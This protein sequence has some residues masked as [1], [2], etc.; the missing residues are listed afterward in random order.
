MANWG[1][2][3]LGFQS[4]MR[5]LD[6]LTIEIGTDAVYVVGSNVEYSVHQ[7]LGTR[8]MEPNPFLRPAAR[9][10]ERQLD[11]IARHVDT[12]DELVREVALFVERRA[13]HY[14]TTNVPPGPDVRTGNLRASIQAE[15]VR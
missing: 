12:G 3:I 14:A 10:A 9:D 13:K 5:A 15:R 7:E 2:R 11:R 6:N 8:N 1:L 4:V